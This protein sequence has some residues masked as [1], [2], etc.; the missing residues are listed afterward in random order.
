MGTIEIPLINCEI[1][2]ILSWWELCYSFCWCR[3]GATFSVN[4]RKLDVAVVTLST[5]DNAKPLEQLKPGCK[6]TIN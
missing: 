2:V 1:Y 5:Q 3:E 6:G 4:V